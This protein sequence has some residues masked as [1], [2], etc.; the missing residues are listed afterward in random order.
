MT[1]Q[2]SAGTPGGGRCVLRPHRTLAAAP[3]LRALTH[4]TR[5]ALIEAIGLAG[6]LTATRASALV[7]ESP[8]ACAYHLRTL[9]RLGFLEEAGGGRGR[10]R[11]CRLARGS[12][13][14]GSSA[15]AELQASTDPVQ[16]VVFATVPELRQLRAQILPLTSRYAGRIDP[17]RRPPGAMP[18]EL[19]T[20]IRV[21]DLADTRGAPA[22]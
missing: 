20:V 22:G 21:L 15:S 6:P 3:S 7:G 13:L 11:P 9:A 5:R 2:P 18:V 16:S 14:T 1:A 19:V 12:R 17:A 4:P 10:E 8:T